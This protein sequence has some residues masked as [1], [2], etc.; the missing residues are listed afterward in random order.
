MKDFTFKESSKRVLVVVYSLNDRN[1][2]FAHQ[3]NV[4]NS[5]SELFPNL[6]VLSIYDGPET[7]S[8]LPFGPATQC[9]WKSNNKL[10]RVPL[11]ILIF[12]RLLI[13]FR[14]NL[15]FFHMV[16]THCALVAPILKL[17]KIKQYLWYA[18][19][20]KS[21]ALR[22]SHCFVNKIITS[23][24][25]SCP[26]VSSKVIAIGQSVD[27]EKFSFV[28]RDREILRGIYIG[29]LD[30]SKRVAHIVEQF[31]HLVANGRLLELD[32]FGTPSN[33]NEEKIWN[34]TRRKLEVH[35]PWLTKSLKG[36]IRHKEIPRLLTGYDFFVNAFQGSL[37][38]TLIEATFSGLPVITTNRE[39]L[40]EFGLWPGCS[41]D[42]SL[43]EQYLTLKRTPAR[44]L[45]TILLKR[46]EIAEQK[47]SLSHWVKSTWEIL[48]S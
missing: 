30:K 33:I 42:S 45:R 19:T 7:S 32:F 13:K 11:Y 16:D 1:V 39:Y 6:H 20:S 46:R 36:E 10:L 15:V 47:H 4:I 27:Q 22:F 2:L 26:I 5:I 23:T 38:K 8:N 44:D 9:G 14:P 37:D 48:E 17:V 24:P 43:I 12:I 41:S 35:Y 28:K 18:H 29:R 31:D 25:G 34:A 40:N 21:I 3:K